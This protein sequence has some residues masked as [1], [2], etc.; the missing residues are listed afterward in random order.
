M[1]KQLLI[2]CAAAVVTVSSASAMAAE[3]S[4]NI[5]FTTDYRYRGVSQTDRDFAIQGGFDYALESGLYMGT[6]ASNVDNFNPSPVTG[7]NGAQ[8]EIDFYVGYGLALSDHWALDFNVLYYY[9]PGASTAGDNNEIDFWEYTPGIAYSDD[10]MSA[11]FSVSY[12]DDFYNESGD[13][14]YYNTSFEFPLEEWLTLGA[15]A[16]YQTVD[17]NDLYFEDYADWSISLATTQFGLDWSVAYIDTDLD[18]TACAGA[19]I[20]GATAVGTISK[21]F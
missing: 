6:W 9:Y 15:H 4:A 14:F 16:G 2:G 1:K 18:D 13:A 10:N 8:A 11:A 19:N 17:E 20:C 7:D 3:A 21:S 12:S 5:A